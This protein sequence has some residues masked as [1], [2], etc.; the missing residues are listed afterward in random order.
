MNVESTVK[1]KNINFILMAA[2]EKVFFIHH[3]LLLDVCM[4]IR[5]V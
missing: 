5:I 1:V 4:R 3:R 2:I